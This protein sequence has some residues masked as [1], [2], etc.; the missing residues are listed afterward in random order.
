MT[1]FFSPHQ[2]MQPETSSSGFSL[3]AILIAI[4]LLSISFYGVNVAFVSAKKSQNNAD[5]KG[6]FKSV[7][8]A[9]RASLARAARDFVFEK[10]CGDSGKTSSE[11]LGDSFT[12]VPIFSSGTSGVVNFSASTSISAPHSSFAEQVARCST[13]KI[14]QFTVGSG[15]G[16]FIYSCFRFSADNTFKSKFMNS[17][18]SFWSLSNSYMEAVMMPVDLRRDEP[19]TCANADS[20]GVGLKIIYTVYYSGTERSGATPNKSDGVFYVTRE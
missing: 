20:P 3:V 16:D 7:Q 17:G 2:K 6:A 18:N 9:M 19:T 4:G 8:P 11:R 1:W 12:D 13:P 15:A 10:K 14:S 5:L